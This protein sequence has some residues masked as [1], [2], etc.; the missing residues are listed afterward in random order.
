M[1]MFPYT[2]LTGDESWLVKMPNKTDDKLNL[3]EFTLDVLQS[4][5]TVFSS[6]N[7]GKL[8]CLYTHI[9]YITLDLL[10]R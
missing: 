6:W 1:S 7:N 10:H 4:L 2:E 8:S 5:K 3:K 9:L